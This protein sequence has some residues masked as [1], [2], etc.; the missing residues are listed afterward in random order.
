MVA[1]TN[2]G[3]GG[4]GGTP[5]WD[6]NGLTD[7][8][9]DLPGMLLGRVTGLG[10]GLL[11]FV[12]KQ[13]IVAAAIIAGLIGAIVGVGL[14]R[15]RPRSRREVIADAIEERVEAVGKGAR[16]AGSKA[17]GAGRALDYG[18]LVPLAMK[19]FENPIVRAFLLRAVAQRMAKKFK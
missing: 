11:D 19:L 2:G 14:A 18:E 8:Y 3:S 4:V 7:K 5:D 1:N 15:R 12:Q 16:K 6:D 17:K 10:G 13:P 9:E